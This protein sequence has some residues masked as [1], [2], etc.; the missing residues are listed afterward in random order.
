MG[1]S[2]ISRL[3]TGIVI[4]ASAVAA[5][6]ISLLPSNAIGGTSIFPGSA[7]NYDGPGGPYGVQN[8]LNQQTGSIHEG[9]YDGSYWLNDGVAAA[10][11]VIDLGA[12]FQIT[13]I[14]LFNTDNGGNNDRGTG[15]FQIDAGN[16]VGAP[17]GNG[18]DINGPLTTI[19]SGTLSAANG[20]DYYLS[21]QSFSV[22]DTGAYRY[23]RF[24]PLTLA[25]SG[26]P[27]SST[28]YGLDEI[29]VFGDPAAV[30]EPAT[31]L[32]AV[33]LLAL[34]WKRRAR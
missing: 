26:T 20:S 16:S 34:L 10:Y 12:E 17:T 1:I 29:R 8:I 21:E 9:A 32:T 6:Q 7:W 30:P 4:L 24:E 2:S 27:Y 33:P 31:W 25:V 23:L 5:G 13:S 14:S 3:L 11:I 22:S 28:A 19:L 15:Q 18:S